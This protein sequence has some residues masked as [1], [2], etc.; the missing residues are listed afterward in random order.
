MARIAFI[1][2]NC[3][4]PILKP[5]EGILLRGN[6]YVANPRDRSGL[7]GNAFPDSVD[8]NVKVSEIKEYAF[9]KGC[10]SQILPWIKKEKKDKDKEA[11]EAEVVK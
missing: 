4:Q 1:C 5:E 2:G 3:S 6:L 10:F 11:K 9:C 8:G 7:V